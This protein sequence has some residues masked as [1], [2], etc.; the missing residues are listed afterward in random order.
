MPHQKSKKIFIYFFL[1]VII[2]T[3][4]NKDLK[5]FNFGK[6]E[7]INVS[8]LGKKNDLQLKKDLNFLKQDNIFFLNKSE[9]SKKLIN[10]QLVEKY[11]VFKKYPSTLNITVN[12]TIFL[13]KIKKGSEIFFLGS[14]GELIKNDEIRKDLPYI[15][16]NFNFKSFF[17]LLDIIEKTNFDYDKIKNLFYFKSGRWDIET[18][19]GL[20][21]KLPQNELEKSLSFLIDFINQ[22]K[23]KPI[24]RIDLRQKNQIIINGK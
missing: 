6:I 16:G 22:N 1:F 23:D 10:N 3:L 19:D 14:N 7:I 13:A 4:N 17:Y 12:K 18:K 20:L 11:S 8:G 2:G 21:I 24:K 5:N 15:F 9:I